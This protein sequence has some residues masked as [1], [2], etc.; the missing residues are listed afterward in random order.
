[1]L[2]CIFY[3]QI[4][5]LYHCFL[6]WYLSGFETSLVFI[7]S[8][9]WVQFSCSLT[10]CGLPHILTC[11]NIWPLVFGAIL[12]G[13]GIFG[14]WSQA[15]GLGILQWALIAMEY[16]CFE[17]HLCL[18]IYTIQRSDPDILNSIDVLI[19]TLPP[20]RKIVHSEISLSLSCFCC[21]V[22]YNKNKSNECI[23]RGQTHLYLA[24]ISLGNEFEKEKCWL[25]HSKTMPTLLLV[26][27][28]SFL[29]K[30]FYISA[31][32]LNK[33]KPSILPSTNPLHYRILIQLKFQVLHTQWPC[34]KAMSGIHDKLLL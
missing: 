25:H 33:N 16:N 2:P 17:S 29:L 9:N 27:A 7:H 34:D 19:S 12:R 13:H 20:P 11:L 18:Q 21:T 30:S 10:C 14:T 4:W 15:G 6:L 22:C 24:F 23:D 32:K 8:Q 3:I 26:S 1:M 5:Y 28:Y 31:Y